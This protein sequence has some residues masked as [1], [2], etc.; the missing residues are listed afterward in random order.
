MNLNWW[1]NDTFIQRH[2]GSSLYYTKHTT[3]NDYDLFSVSR[4]KWRIKSFFFFLYRKYMTTIHLFIIIR[5][6]VINI[7]SCQIRLI[8]HAFLNKATLIFF[9]FISSYKKPLR[10][11]CSIFNIHQMFH[12]CQSSNKT[13]ILFNLIC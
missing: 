2:M 13:F 9:N 11:F 6:I 4:M 5:P 8:W 12:I 10:I 3:L 7:R 1:R